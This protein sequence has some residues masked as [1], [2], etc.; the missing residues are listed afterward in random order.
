MGFASWVSTWVLGLDNQTRAHSRLGDLFHKTGK[1]HAH[2]FK[3][4]VF[5]SKFHCI[6]KKVMVFRVMFVNWKDKP[7]SLGSL[8]VV[9]WPCVVSCEPSRRP[10]GSSSGAAATCS[11][12]ASVGSIPNAPCL[13]SSSYWMSFRS[14]DKTIHWILSQNEPTEKWNWLAFLFSLNDQCV[15]DLGSRL[16]IGAS[17]LISREPQF[18]YL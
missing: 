5:L 7:R 13:L 2:V 10:M 9:W 15:F 16:W 17:Y 18:A 3:D 1:E 11:V 4:V 8:R 14:R 6:F 12:S